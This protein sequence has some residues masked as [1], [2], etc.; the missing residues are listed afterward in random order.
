MGGCVQANLSLREENEWLKGQLEMQRQ[1]WLPVWTH[2]HYGDYVTPVVDTYHQVCST[3]PAADT[4][5]DCTLDKLRFCVLM[6]ACKRVYRRSVP[7]R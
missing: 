4:V 3:S 1:T 6:S 7:R 5:H 2:K